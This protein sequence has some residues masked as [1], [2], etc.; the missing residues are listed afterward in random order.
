MLYSLDALAGPR[1]EKVFFQTLYA[2]L[3]GVFT[4]FG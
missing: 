2:E 3:K 4:I 1:G